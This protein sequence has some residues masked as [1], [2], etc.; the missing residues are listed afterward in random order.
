MLYLPVL[1]SDH[2][3][4][5]LGIVLRLGAL[6]SLGLV[7]FNFVSEAVVFL[8]EAHQLNGELVLVLAL[9]V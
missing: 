3:L 9:L 5:T 6:L 7:D 2:S 8:S 1:V 4:L